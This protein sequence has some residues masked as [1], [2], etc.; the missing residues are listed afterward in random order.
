MKINE[1]FYSLQGEG[2]WVGLPTVFIRTA[3]CNLRCTYCD[4]T[5]AYDDGKDMN[6]DEILHSI[7]SY[8]CPFVCI[9][10]GEPL[11]QK[12]L[13]DILGALVRKHYKICV[14]TN[15]SKSVKKIVRKKSVIISLDI[16][17]P[18]SRMQQ[19]M[20]FTNIALLSKNDQIKFIIKRKEDYEYAKKIINTY[21]PR[22]MV[23]LQPVWGTD[24]RRL[25][26]WIL[27]DGLPVR[28]GVQLHKIVWGEKKGV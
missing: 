2:A 19:H 25:A 27:H 22:C 5:Y 7:Q 11:L 23:F 4:T 13:M 15:G 10:G 12:D 1:I 8:K 6:V 21:K 14:E 16:K 17:C 24:P 9:T 28:L 18:S 26:S 20:I 3:G